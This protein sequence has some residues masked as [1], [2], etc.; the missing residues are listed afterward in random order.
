MNTNNPMNE[1]N[2]NRRE[3]TPKTIIDVPYNVIPPT[4]NYY[5]E[6][7]KEHDKKKKGGWSKFLVG[8]MV[9]SLVGGTSIGA[10]FAIT[11]PYANALYERN[12]GNSLP[13]ATTAETVGNQVADTNAQQVSYVPSYNGTNPIPDIADSVGPS[14]VS[15]QNNK[16]VA[17]WSGEFTQSGLGSG[18]IFKED[19]EKVYIM[20]NAHVV[21]GASTLSVTLLGNA[22]VPAQI[23][24]YD[25]VT[26]IAVV[27]VLQEDIPEELR[28]QIKPAP[29]G[30]SD[31]LRVGDMAIAIGT[32]INEAYNNTVTVG[33][34][35]ALDRQINLT[36]Q[37]FNLIQTDAAINPGNSG[38]ALVGPTG[39]VIGINTIKLVDSEIEGM[40]FAIPIN[41]V[42]P[43]VE[44][45]MTHGKIIRP[46]LGI[47]GE[48]LQE[49]LG[50][51]WEIP[52]G[53]LIHEVVPGSSA[54]L[55]GIKP[56]DIIIEFDNKRISTVE[57]LQDILLEKQVGDVSQVKVVRGS[58]KYEANVKLQAM[59]LK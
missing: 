2:E 34:I 49:E 29:L 3:E 42:K 20:S 59:P 56:G 57:E 55:A 17:N 10:G 36:D 31:S 23:V 24:G 38:G 54:D 30:D 48:N 7:I 39:E 51:Y 52:V 44:E 11:A 27:S 43:I 21:E 50:S 35:S 15:I 45:I 1:N 14:V 32:P 19:E 40:G 28:E 47:L 5:H 13:G 8:V 25:T 37:Q 12:T 58:Q 18:V 41:D 16:I 9:A 53:I 26:D 6:T 46:S 33:Y 22:K 4:S